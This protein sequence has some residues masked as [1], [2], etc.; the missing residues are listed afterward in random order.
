MRVRFAASAFFFIILLS[1]S[2][3]AQDHGAPLNPQDIRPLPKPQPQ[4]VRVGGNVQAASLVSRVAPEYPETAK[5]AHISGTV[6]LHAIISK[7]GSVESLE[8]ISG[9]QLLMKSAMDAVRQWRYKP[10]LLNGEPVEVDTTVSVV[11]KLEESGGKVDS[12]EHTQEAVKP[13][14]PTDNQKPESKNGAGDYSHE[15]VVYEYLHHVLRYENDGTGTLELHGRVRVQTSAGLETAGQLIF[16]YNAA[17][18]TIEIRTVRVEKPD[19]TVVNA[20]SE[21]VQDLTAPVARLAP[22]YSDA[23]QKHV[24]V[25]SLAVGDAVEY[26]VVVNSTP[27]VAGQFWHNVYFCSNLACPDEQVDLDIPADRKINFVSPESTTE[28]T[29]RDAGDRRIYHWKASPPPIS[30]I[31]YLSPSR[32]KVRNLLG[33]NSPPL[34]PHIFFSTFQ[35]WSEV[36]NWYAGLVR[37]RRIP[38]PEIRAKADEIVRGKT[39]DLEKAQALYRWVSANIRYVSLS[40]GEGR[41]Q[42]HAAPEVLANRYGDCKDKATLLAAFFTAEGLH[43]DPVLIG[44]RANLNAEVP[45]PAQFDHVINY[46]QV[47]GK[48]VWLDSTAGVGPYG[49]LLPS[50]RGKQALVVTDDSSPKLE[51]TIDT[52]PAP[53]LYRVEVQGEVNKDA[54]L[55]ATVKL[56]TQGDLEVLYRLWYSN[57]SAKQLDSLA[58]LPLGSALKATYGAKVTDFVVEDPTDT[59]KPLHLQ[60]HFTGDLLYVNVVSTSRQVFLVALNK[61]LLAALLPA[62]QSNLTDA[63]KVARARVLCGELLQE[64]QARGAYSLAVA[65]KVPTV[66]TDDT[67]EPQAARYAGSTSEYDASSHWDG[68]TLHA[69]WK[70]NIGITQM[71]DAQAEAFPEFCENVAGLLNADVRKERNPTSPVADKNA[72]LTPGPVPKSDNTPAPKPDTP[73]V[74]AAKPIPSEATPKDSGERLPLHLPEVIELYNR[75]QTETK[76]QN[77]ANA[78]ESFTSVLKMEPQYPEAW[79]ELGRAQMYLR[80]YL[81]AESAFR[82]YLALAPDDH[83]AYLN[84]AWA[85]Y[86][87]KKYAEEVDMLEKRIASAPND[88]DANAR[89]GSAYLAL[90]HPE[91]ALPVLQKAVSIFP[92]YEYPQFNLA[93]AYLQLHEEDRAAAEFQRAI[94]IDDTNNTRNSAAY[95]LAQANTHLE[96]ATYWA[97]RAIE[98]VELELTQAKFPLQPATMR[99]VSSIAAYWDTMGWI[100]FQQGNLDAAEKYILAASELADDSTILLHLGKVYEARGRKNEAIELYAEALAAVPSTRELDDDEME[101]RARLIGLLGGDSFVEGRVMQARPRITERHSTPIPNPVR[102]EGIVQYAVIVGPESKVIDIQ[103]LSPDDSLAGLKESVRIA[104]LPQSFPD[105][106]TH[107]LPRAGTLSCPRA[108]LPCTFTFTSASA[109]SRVIS[110]D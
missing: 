55:D 80:N 99:R 78:V 19:G 96:I 79:R 57:Y 27:E 88:G 26:D 72:T 37:D 20:G 87:E 86:N 46:A 52:L 23:R 98:A 44:S 91:K 81:D 10:T 28:L 33:G 83:L 105:D 34:P 14:Q 47:E 17:N 21:N 5:R 3:S 69:N 35:S 97:Y 6:M 39:G 56:E 4:R 101:A 61:A 32:Y 76:Q 75:G 95:A 58:A 63:A 104:T 25:P 50:L 22:V 16:D 85:L 1:T 54:K 41:Y 74:S 43:A 24:T 62:E 107:R 110:T 108:G 15:P 60:F 93:R 29:I 70:L 100:R 67:D 82:K 31:D 94:N 109:A 30:K 9:P 77:Y 7:D 90:H 12:R 59:S 40:F 18:E 102:A 71:S 8:Y 2:T 84:M 38:T 53:S 66:K 42:P 106:T 48:N 68:Q 64:Q 13:A 36:G 11:F 89:L 73:V 103:A 45:S 92:K 65:I 49:Y 51:K